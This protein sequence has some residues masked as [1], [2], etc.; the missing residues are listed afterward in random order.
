MTETNSRT[1]TTISIRRAVLLALSTALGS[2]LAAS[3]AP[4]QEWV[5]PGTGDWFEPTN[6]NPAVVPGAGS[7]PLVSNGG[8]AKLSGVAETPF[9]SSLNVGQGG[10]GTGVGTVESNGV[11]IRAGTFNVGTLFS[12][13]DTAT[14]DLSIVAAG[15]EG[16]SLNVGLIF[17]PPG[18]AR[19]TGSLVVEGA[20]PLTGGFL[21][22]GQ[23]IQS[24]RGSVAEG[25][26]E[27]GGDAGTVGGF[28][29][30]GNVSGNAG[31]A[32]SSS[33]GVLR[34]KNGGGLALSGGTQ[35]YVGTTLGT[36]WE[37]EGPDVY[38]SR[39]TGTVAID[40]TLKFLG[41]PGSS[42]SATR[43]AASPTGR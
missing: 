21:Q 10:I 38:V 25:T 27:I 1:S 30:V 28:L 4:A 39:A 18:R 8:T 35:V 16:N 17:T 15:A 19:A 9:L 3:S 13:G 12:S 5:N 37:V 23:M 29:I 22:A 31:Q 36:D 42:G 40:G 6:W 2:G 26:V 41:S 32:G 43:T 14:G 33:T 7:N 11:K 34:V 24:G 20:L